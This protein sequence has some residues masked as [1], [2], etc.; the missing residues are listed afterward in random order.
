MKKEENNLRDEIDD[1]I[2]EQIG[3]EKGIAT[4]F[5]KLKEKKGWTTPQPLYNVKNRKANLTTTTLHDIG[6]VDDNF[7]ADMA[8]FGEYR[9][10]SSM[11]ELLER[12]AKIEL[13][14]ERKS[15]EAR[16]NEIRAERAE[17][18]NEVLQNALKTSMKE[19]G[20]NFQTG[21]TNRLLAD[22]IL[23]MLAYPAKFNEGFN[24]ARP[25]EIN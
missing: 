16:K 24:I 23:M 22:D 7:S 6:T 25:I 17:A 12:I 19:N 13:N 4:T 2:L 18:L 9:Y 15:E 3:G 5:N 20:V 10:P 11:K 1:R 14:F 21:D 8:I